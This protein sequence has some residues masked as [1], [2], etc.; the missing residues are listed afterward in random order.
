V[1]KVKV[2][3]GH[4]GNNGL[5][6]IIAHCG[7]EFVRIRVGV[8]KPKGGAAQGA[9]WVLGRF[10]KQER[11]LVDEALAQ[12]GQAVLSVVSEGVQAAMNKFNRRD[13]AQ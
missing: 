7:R 3:G 10:D 11:V 4:G 1:V 13:I 8:G 5:K 12:A 2:G 6:S 9:N